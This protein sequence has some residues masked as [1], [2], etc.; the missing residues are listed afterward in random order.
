M[1]SPSFGLNQHEFLVN[2]SQ[3]VEIYNLFQAP[4]VRIVEYENKLLKQQQQHQD[5][6]H[7]FRAIRIRHLIHKCS[8]HLPSNWSRKRGIQWI[9]NGNKSTVNRANGVSA[10]E[11]RMS[12]SPAHLVPCLNIIKKLLCVCI[13]NSTLNRSSKIP[14]F[15]HQYYEIF[16]VSLSLQ[17]F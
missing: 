4:Q 3:E 13:Y 5:A 15:W 7:S 11:S 6:A 1:F 8:S 9:H 2:Q 16:K 10:E 14:L 12:A 17:Y